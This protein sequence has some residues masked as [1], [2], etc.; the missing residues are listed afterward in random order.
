MQTSKQ[1]KYFDERNVRQQ[2]KCGMLNHFPLALYYTESLPRNIFQN[3]SLYTSIVHVMVKMTNND[4]FF[5]KL[6]SDSTF[7]SI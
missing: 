7:Y 2:S 5:L 3:L 1:G 6:K 4:K